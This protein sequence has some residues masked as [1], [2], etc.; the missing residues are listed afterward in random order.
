MP[1]ES[2]L[3]GEYLL[4][5][6]KRYGLSQQKAADLIGCGRRSWQMWEYNQ[7]EIPRYIELA[8][9]EASRIIEAGKLG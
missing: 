6:R 8:L 4:S 9:R 3:T 2:N 5:W 1:Q 7:S